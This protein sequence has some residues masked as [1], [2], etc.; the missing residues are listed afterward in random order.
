[1]ED[2]MPPQEQGSFEDPIRSDATYT[3]KVS[4]MMVLICKP[5]LFVLGSMR[6]MATSISVIG[7]A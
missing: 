1:M 5:I 6:R 3:L 4:N 7:M 2:M